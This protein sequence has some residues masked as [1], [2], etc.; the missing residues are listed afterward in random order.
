M[1]SFNS[2]DL[3]TAYLLVNKINKSDAPARE[4]HSENLSIQDGFVVVSN[5]WRSRTITIAGTL[6]ASSSAHLGTLLDELKENLSGVNKNLDVDYAG[7]T[8]RYKATLSKL[9]APEDFYNITHLPYTAE[10]VCQP[11]GYGT[12]EISFT[13]SDVT[14]ASQDET[15]TITGTYR[16]NPLITITFGTSASATSVVLTN[17]STGDI[18]TISDTFTDGDVLAINTDT[19]KVTKNG[20]QIEF[21]GP[22]PGFVTGTNYITIDMSGT[23]INYD[24]VITYT[25]LYL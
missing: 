3:Q 24:L 20:T 11:F 4:L 12:S 2:N 14:A 9:D 18:I 10:F 1:I 23:T 6:D 7:G 22:M 15:L 21:S 19:H 25:P 17:T 5:Y 8:R 13:S 16:P